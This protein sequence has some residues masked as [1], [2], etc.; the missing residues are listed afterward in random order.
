MKMK[1]RMFLAVTLSTGLLAPTLYGD[2]QP[3]AV[4]T[5][6]PPVIPAESPKASAARKAKTTATPARKAAATEPKKES[7]ALEAGP[8]MV[9]Q[10]SVVVRGQAAI[11]SEIV[12]RLKGGDK[13]TILEIK[14]IKPKMDEPAKWARIAMPSTVAVW[15]NKSFIDDATKTVKPKKLNL[16][17]GPGENFSVVGHLEKGAAIKEIESKGDWIKI[18]PPA[19]AYAFVAAHLLIRVPDALAATSATAPKIADATPPPVPIQTINTPPPVVT[20]PPPV[21]TPPP[22]VAAPPPVFTPPPVVNPPPPVLVEVV[23]PKPPPPPAEDI[24]IKRVVTREGIVNRA[25]S[26][27]SPT[28]FIL[29]SLDNKKTIN[30]L[31]SPSTNIALKSFFGQRILITGEELLDER[32][33]NTPVINV[34]TLQPVEQ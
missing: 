1:H 27:Q 32:W 14:T 31:Y 13:V 8:A 4:T 28:H 34:E 17:G 29:E 33:P 20:P 22:V 2:E 16:R 11:N 18:E 23:T 7:A 15:V 6:K 9:S 25:V 10:K 3:G 12:T 26:V 24:L 21:F 30:Y 5:T 19:G